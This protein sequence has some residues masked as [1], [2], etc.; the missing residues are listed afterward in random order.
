[1]KNL[2]ISTVDPSHSYI[3]ASFG[4]IIFIMKF[5]FCQSTL[6]QSLLN[7]LK[8]SDGNLN[9]V[10]RISYASQ[11]P[12]VFSATLRENVTFGREFKREHYDRVLNA[13]ALDKV[14]LYLTF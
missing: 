6:L 1:M 13:C 8:L 3:L 9:I 11:D 4:A 14:S 7:E 5:F 2:V 10:G 12:W